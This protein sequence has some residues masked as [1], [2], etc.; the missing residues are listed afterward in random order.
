[1][2]LRHV[3]PRAPHGVL[4]RVF[5]RIVGT[6]PM[7]W[8]SRKVGWKV[9]PILMRLTRGR[10]GTGGMLPTA[11]IETRGR[12]T[13]QVRR[14]AVIYFNDGDD[15]I[16]VASRLGDPVHPAWFLNARANPDVKV[17]DEPY[18]AEVVEDEAERARLW[19]L[20]DRV[21]PAYAVYRDRAAGA[22]RTI[23]ILRLRPA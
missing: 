5:A 7:G 16:V 20:A 2:A 18:R 19:D 12:R 1:M 23:Q 13:G 14:N 6:R 21:F 15:V 22:G 9:D 3:D 10:F 4:Y 17:N 8:V 11:L